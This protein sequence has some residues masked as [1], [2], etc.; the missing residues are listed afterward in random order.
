MP[1]N[2]WIEN[3]RTNRFDGRKQNKNEWTDEIHLPKLLLYD[4]Q[5]ENRYDLKSLILLRNSTKSTRCLHQWSQDIF[6]NI[7]S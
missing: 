7:I 6:Q 3:S 4:I 5:I 1:E 2:W